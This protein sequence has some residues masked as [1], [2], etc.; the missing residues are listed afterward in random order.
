MIPGKGFPID[1]GLIG[2]P[3]K[4]VL[5][6]WKAVFV[7]LQRDL[8][9]VHDDDA[10]QTW[11]LVADLAHF[12]E[13]L[14]LSIDGRGLGCPDSLPKARPPSSTCQAGRY[15]HYTSSQY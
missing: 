10:P 6:I 7:W 15:G 1:P 5:S 4:F 13:M 14:L 3:G 12:V 11:K 2:I 8:L 9:R